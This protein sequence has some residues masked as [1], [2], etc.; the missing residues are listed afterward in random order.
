MKKSVTKTTQRIDSK[1]EKVESREYYI[2]HID[3]I[4][5]F[6]KKT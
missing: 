4:V 5:A 1:E 6:N 2:R 3:D